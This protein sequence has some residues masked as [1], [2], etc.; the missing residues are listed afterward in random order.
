MVYFRE[1][2][3]GGRGPTFSRASNIANSYVNI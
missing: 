2:S 3:S 1:T